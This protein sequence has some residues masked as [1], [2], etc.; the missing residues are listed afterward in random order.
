[1]KVGSALLV[2]DGTDEVLNRKAEFSLRP[3]RG[4]SVAL[5][6]GLLTLARDTYNAALQHRRDAW[7]M[8][9]VS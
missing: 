7:R 8:A 3:S 2:V 6:R 1:M 5:E 4:Q 9:G